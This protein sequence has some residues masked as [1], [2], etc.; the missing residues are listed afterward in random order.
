MAQFNRREFASLAAMLPAL[1]GLRTP[2]DLEYAGGL[3][4]I[5]GIRVGHFTHQRRP[6]GCTVILTER[7]A[8]AAVDVRGSA[9]GTRETDL[10]A[11]NKTIQKIHAIVLAGGSAFGLD[12][13][14]GVV[15]YLEERGVGFPTRKGPVP[16]VPAAILYDLGLGDPS[17][18]PDRE[19]GYRACQ[20]AHTGPVQ[21]GNVGA[22]AGAT[23]GKML[24]AD[25]AMKAGLG[26]AALRVDQLTVAALV[27]VNA[28]G[29][30]VDPESG[31]ILA[32]ARSKDGKSFV[33]L[34]KTLRTTTLTGDP[35]SLE[36][37]TLGVVATN[38]S[39]D[40]PAMQT[41]AEMSHDGLART[42][43]PVHTPFDGDTIFSI[44]TGAVEGCDL[45][46]VGALAAQVISLAVIRSVLQARGIPDYP[47][48]SDL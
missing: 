9:P 12:S 6:T 13:A 30:V 21:E 17:I 47:A 15:Q 10:L 1:P 36:N 14:S 4:D 5:P 16:I 33:D 35:T 22:G 39:F 29:D 23:V 32:G 48:H 27:A 19:A 8:T 37:T 3:T 42:I 18:R 44:S 28:V 26:S 20:R 24:G 31:R 7:G 38:A 11:P 46:Q 41:V 34:A 40:K 45:G 2:E 25:R 43:H